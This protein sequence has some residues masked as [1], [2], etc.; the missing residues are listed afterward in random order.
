MTSLQLSPQAAAQ[1]LRIRR[2]ARRDILHYVNAIEVPG[3][4][5]GE[6]PEG[7]FF[8]PVETTVA[9]H[10][11]L[12]LEK[13][14]ETSK[15]PH[16]RLMVFMPPGSAKSTYASV[17]FP[18]RYLGERPGRRLILASYGDDLARKMGRR[19]RSIIRQ[20]RYQQIFE[21]GLMRDS[22]AAQEFGLTNG[23]EYIAC[24]MLSGIT[25]NRAH[26]IIIDDPV[27]GREQAESETIRQK[28]WDSY[29]DDLKT[30][31]IP[32]G[33]ICL[34]QTRWHQDDLAGRIL[35]EDWNGESGKILCRDGNIWEVLCLQAR[36]E[37]DDDPLGRK[38]GEYLWPEWFDRKHWAQF[39]SNPRTWA[40][41]FQQLPVPLDGE[42]FKPDQLK[43]VDAAP[44]GVRIRKV[45]GWDLA[46]TTDG[47]W[48][49]GALLGVLPDNR[50]IILDMNRFRRLPDERDAAMINTAHLDGRSVTIDIPQDPGQAGKTQ[51]LYLTRQL[52]GFKVQS[53]PESGDKV[54]RA[55]PFASQVNVGNVMMLRGPWNQPLIDEMRSFPGSGLNDDQID[56]LSRAFAR[57]MSKSGLRIS[58][59]A[60]ARA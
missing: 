27:K 22:Q 43:I 39:E 12:L 44:A 16:G 7:E 47:D 8:L 42:L 29:E 40:A 10:H 53:S 21:T 35:P 30:R 28:T 50:Y 49:A 13:L 23:S 33:W 24:G 55:E 26:G 5:A 37:V 25:G 36:C 15:T 31:L 19:T 18:S 34:I 1:E 14:E 60:I 17:V 51:V 3:K 52:H 20:S 54:T 38:R 2:A 58:E 6:D 48:S 57:L 46:S 56:A 32:G 41:L 9:A 45:R 59:S 4:P 11:R